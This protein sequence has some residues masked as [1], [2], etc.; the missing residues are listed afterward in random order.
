MDG[1]EKLNTCAFR[2]TTEIA[3]IIQRCSCRGGNYEVKGY[4]CN[5][6]QIFDVKP[7]ICQ[8]CVEYQKLSQ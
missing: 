7:E 6:K 3:K 5:R 1:S 2:S 8:T 4:F